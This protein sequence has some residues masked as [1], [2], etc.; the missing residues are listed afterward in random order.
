ML[1]SKG[2][3]EFKIWK[4]KYSDGDARGPITFANVNDVIL[5]DFKVLITLIFYREHN[6]EMKTEIEF[7]D[8]SFQKNV[9]YLN[10]RAIYI[11]KIYTFEILCF[12]IF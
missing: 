7:K 4:V 12:S 9:E 6:R 8:P 3:G 5:K 11:S 1:R 2:P 10:S